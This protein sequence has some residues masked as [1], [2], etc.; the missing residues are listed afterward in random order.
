M[1]ICVRVYVAMWTYMLYTHTTYMMCTGDSGVVILCTYILITSR[2]LER[3]ATHQTVRRL[4]E[5]RT[6]G[7]RDAMPLKYRLRC[8]RP[9]N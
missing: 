7:L 8:A 1:D 4:P 9:H 3:H 6:G 5:P 2:R